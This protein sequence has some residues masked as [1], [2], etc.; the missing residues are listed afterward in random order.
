MAGENKASGQGKAKLWLCSG[1][2]MKLKAPS[3][4]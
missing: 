1:I 3:C 4:S 2:A